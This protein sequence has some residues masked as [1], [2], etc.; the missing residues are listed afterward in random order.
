MELFLRNN[1]LEFSKFIYE[2]IQILTI[3]YLDIRYK[4][5]EPDKPNLNTIIRF[6]YTND[7][8]PF[9]MKGFSLIKKTIGLSIMP[10]KKETT[11][12]MVLTSV[13]QP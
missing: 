1:D 12:R 4:L 2:S 7:I 9:R 6:I 3:E 13:L 10:I 11:C 5:S 8:H